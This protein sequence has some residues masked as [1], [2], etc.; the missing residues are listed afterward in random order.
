MQQLHSKASGFGCLALFMLIVSSSQEC[1]GQQTESRIVDLGPQ[2]FRMDL[3]LH[4]DALIA[5]RDGLELRTAN[6]RRH[7][8]NPVVVRDRSW[9]IGVFNYTCV[10]QDREQGLYKMWYQM[11]VSNPGDNKS[12][13]HYAFSRDG[14]H[15]EKPA[16]GVVEFEGSKENNIVFEEL[17]GI[18]GTPSYWVYK[19]YAEVDPGKRYK[20]MLQSWGF[21]G[22]SSKMAWS[23]DGVHWTMSEYGNLPGPFDS[24]NGFYWDDRIGQYAGYFRSHERGYRSVSRA[25][26][27]DGYHGSRPVPVHTV[28]DHDPPTWHLYIPGVYQYGAA[29]NTYIMLTTGYDDTANEMYPQLG[30]S[31][32][33]VHFHRF[34]E[35]FIPPG[36]KG[37]WDAGST[38]GI[39]SEI[40]FEG[41]TGLYYHGSSVGGHVDGGSQGIGL[42]TI[43]EAT[44]GESD[45]LRVSLRH[46]GL[47][48]I[49]HRERQTGTGSLPRLELALPVTVRMQ[50]ACPDL[51]AVQ[52]VIRKRD[53][54]DQFDVATSLQAC[55]SD[56]SQFHFLR[57]S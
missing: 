23:P 52:H 43:Q 2:A 46:R 3:F 26:S 48:C 5:E 34:R 15:W 21:Q 45:G 33:G 38:R 24:Q 10:I 53:G 44:R 35:P 40:V 50:C 18:R 56:P 1:R 7:P 17:D 28:D 57:S 9:E 27:P 12:R 30:I 13:C 54:T 31:R 8:A 39:G 16:L 11:I 47:T 14:I 25:T 37:T 20:M 19:D 22:R 49:S 4:D 36:D 41:Q 32:D 51:P 29:R 55:S 6:I 42:A